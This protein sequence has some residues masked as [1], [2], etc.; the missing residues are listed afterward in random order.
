MIERL[1]KLQNTPLFHRQAEAYASSRAK[2]VTSLTWEQKKKRR[3][4]SWKGA[5]SKD[6]SAP[7]LSN[8]P[9]EPRLLSWSR[10]K[11]R[12]RDVSVMQS[13]SRTP[14]RV[15][16]CS[17]VGAFEG[18][19]RNFNQALRQQLSVSFRASL[20]FLL[21]FASSVSV[22]GCGLL[23]HHELEGN[24]AEDPQTARKVHRHTRSGK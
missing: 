12:K 5:T 4:P 8:P 23:L 16:F 3:K 6:I 7:Q 13:T 22:F 11:Q 18:K 21:L 14:A 10:T 1:W 2:P 20:R 19:G 24:R 15:P 9:R 17:A